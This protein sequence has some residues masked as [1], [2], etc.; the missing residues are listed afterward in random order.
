MVDFAPYDAPDVR[1]AFQE[2]DDDAQR[3]QSMSAGEARRARIENV[4]RLRQK[5]IAL[6]SPAER[7]AYLKLP[8]HEDF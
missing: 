8:N 1:S 5:L 7:Q 3:V 4:H 6:L 2:A